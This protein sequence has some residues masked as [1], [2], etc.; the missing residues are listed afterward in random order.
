MISSDS[1]ESLKAHVSTSLLYLFLAPVSCSYPETARCRASA[2]PMGSSQYELKNTENPCH[3]EL[4][5]IFI[6]FKRSQRKVT[7][8]LK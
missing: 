1:Q 8:V 4:V 5:I 2:S 3:T 6:L 7:Q